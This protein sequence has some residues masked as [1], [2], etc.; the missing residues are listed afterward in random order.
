MN[1]AKPKD[2]SRL[3]RPEILNFLFHP[4]PEI[5]YGAS[6]N[7]GRDLLIPVEGQVSVGAR[8]HHVDS[9]APNIL[10]FHGN[11]EIVADYDDIG[12][13][14]GRTGINFLAVDYRGY[15]RSTGD[16]TVTSMMNDCHRVFDFVSLWLRE[17][18]FRGPLV[19]M[20]RSL[21]SAPAIELASRLGGDIDG[22]IIESGFA[23]TIPLLRL[24]GVDLQRLG[25][26]EEDGCGNLE[27]IRTV[28]IPTLFI[29]AQYDFIIP[30][31]DGEAL[32]EA[33][34]AREKRLVMIPG[35]DHN[36]VFMIGYAMYMGAISTFMESVSKR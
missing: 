5:R 4:R 33:S 17:E 24:I 35:A 28:S 23:Y 16:P 25:I 10:F 11:G 18:G 29:H 26:S 19:V 32:T 13:I 30:F 27:K 14:Y 7:S 31:T 9:E 34:P 20:G 2:Y 22:L 12:P 1:E 3:D 15:G 36:T 21:G 6:G 8:F